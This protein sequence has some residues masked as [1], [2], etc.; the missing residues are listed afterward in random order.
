MELNRSGGSILLHVPVDPLFL[1]IPIITSL[2]S[3]SSS[4]AA[5][6]QPLGDLIA[7]ASVDPGF[8]LPEPFSTEPLASGSRGFNEDITRL[9]DIK[10]V[11]RVLRACCEKK[12]SS[13]PDSDLLLTHAS[14]PADMSVVPTGPPSPP[15]SSSSI[16]LDK[17]NSSTYYRPSTGIIINHL[18][19]KIEHFAQP[20]QY[21]KFDHLVRGLGRDGL[22]ESSANQDML[23]CESLLVIDERSK[24][25]E[26]KLKES[27]GKTERVD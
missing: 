4:S 19:R 5:R 25:P 24:G 14:A 8:A 9:L 15:S 13:Q 7:Q 21:E 20:E 23:R 12:G 2:L 16:T 11:R 10:P 17:V 18:K 22:L 3:S 1:V 26:S 6:F 27:S